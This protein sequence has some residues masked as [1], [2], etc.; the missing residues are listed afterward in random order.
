MGGCCL[1]RVPFLVIVLRII[2]FRRRLVVGVDMA[3]GAVTGTGP[4][5]FDPVAIG[6]RE[7]DVWASYYRHEWLAFLRAAV[8]MVRVSFGMSRRR[9]LMG[10]WHVLRANQVWAPVSDN[11]PDAAREHMRRFYALVARSGWPNLDPV[12]AAALEV[13]WWRVHRL[14]QRGPL[15]GVDGASGEI[16]EDALVGALVALY[17]YVYHLPENS[18]RDAARL[19]VEAMD[20]SDAWV[21][22]GCDLDH[23]LLMRERL[24]LVASYTALREAID[25]S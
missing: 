13:E 25:R 20:A 14:H 9:T 3:R 21:D 1:F 2:V 6:Q 8:G 11:D 4:R 19:R 16:A 15:A 5:D 24:L 17:A 22:A 23:P 18:V 12:R 10:A 7:C